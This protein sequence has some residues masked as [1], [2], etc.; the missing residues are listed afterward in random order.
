MEEP[1]VKVG[2]C[3]ANTVSLTFVSE[4]FI[5]YA[6]INLLAVIKSELPIQVSRSMI[7]E[8]MK[9][10]VQRTWKLCRPPINPMCLR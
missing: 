5:K 4:Y 7:R 8:A 6:G 3:S 9:F 10:S 2:I 1:L